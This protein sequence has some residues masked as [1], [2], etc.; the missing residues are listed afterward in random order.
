MDLKKV[1]LVELNLIGIDYMESTPESSKSSREDITITEIV[2]RCSSG[3]SDSSSDGDSFSYFS[4][5]IHQ[6]YN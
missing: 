6:T 4:D 5:H 1:V 3:N 2:I